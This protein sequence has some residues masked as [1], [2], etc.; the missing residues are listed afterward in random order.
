MPLESAMGARSGLIPYQE[1]QSQ[2]E[3]AAKR[4]RLAEDQYD[5]DDD[6][7]PEEREQFE[8]L[9][10][11]TKQYD[12]AR[13]AREPFDTFDACWDLFI[14]NIYPRQWPS[15]R[16]KIVINKIRAFVTFMQAIM[17]D[18]KPRFSVE[19]VVNGS[20]DAADLLTKLADRDW[21]E[22]D[23]QQKIATFVL[24]GLVW[25]TGFMKVAYDPYANGGRGKHT[26]DVIVP[27]RIWSNRT[28][29]TVNEAEGCEYIIHVE[30]KT[31]GWI[32]RNF[33][34]RANAVW[35][36]RGKRSL[37]ENERGKDRDY[38]REGDINEKQRIITA[39]SVD[40]N[41]TG[42]QF[43]VTQPQWAEDD[44][45]II[46]IRDHWMH[47]ETYEEY[48]RQKVVGG[49][50]QF[51][52]IVD[53]EGITVFEVTGHQ[54]RTSEI[55]GRPFLSPIRKP[56]V[57]P[58]MESAWRL[59]Y[60]NGRLVTIAGGKVILRDIP[61][62]F[63]IDGFP[64][65]MWKD[66]DVGSFWGQGEPLPLKDCAI[67]TSRLASQLYDILE[68]T[69]NPQYKIKKGGGVN[70]AN[71]RNKAGG[72]VY[73]DDMDA[74]APLEKPVVPQQFIELYE[75][76]HKAMGE[77]CGVNDSVTG[78]LAASNTAFA[79]MDQLQE[80]GAAPIRQK[81]RNLESGITRI[82]KLRVQLI[83]QYD[84]GQRPLRLSDDGAEKTAE[85]VVEPA[86]N[87]NVQFR[88]YTNA[89]LQGQVEFGVVPISSLSTSPAGAWNRWQDMYAKHLVDRRWWHS[90]FRIEGWRTELPRMELQEQKDKQDEAAT[91]AAGKSKPGPA[92]KTTPRNGRRAKPPS[93][94]AT[95][96]PSR[97][98]NAAVR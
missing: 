12:D 11:C 81:V 61:I 72:L 15:W 68:K 30:D 19:P 73:M 89:D 67:A 40:G 94:P 90:K 5:E 36:I 16:A 20:E 27:Y 35:A 29:M 75:L 45:D 47:D 91:K 58:V 97:Q 42:P 88:Q 22:N 74:M 1:W 57:E 86:S 43:S 26:A 41:V 56:T 98:Q 8:I 93:A 55:D 63:Q 49:R 37:Q 69:G 50:P 80:S 24:Y 77:I 17:T 92:P 2:N 76:L 31:M 83:Q 78:N 64:F 66:Y 21:D 28:A 46:E 25:G 7:S 32:R 53:D 9:R 85:G 96:T 38:I 14:G 51:K 48:E 87:V 18:N 39:Q 52:N 82:G 34:S 4:R 23:M 54:M 95:H 33:A 6:L 13:K 70:S 44:T 84:H 79:T 10:Y 62:P 3:D 65:A 71:I 59:K 60:P